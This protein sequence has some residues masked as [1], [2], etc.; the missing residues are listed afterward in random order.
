MVRRSVV[1]EAN[2]VLYFICRNHRVKSVFITIK[3]RN[4]RQEPVTGFGEYD[5]EYDQVYMC[6]A[7]GVRSPDPPFPNVRQW[8]LAVKKVGGKKQLT[9]KGCVFAFQATLKEHE[10]QGSVS[11]FLYRSNRGLTRW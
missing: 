10:Q 5:S 11:G 2:K 1:N 4:L 9:V 7:E 6:N 8:G 3:L